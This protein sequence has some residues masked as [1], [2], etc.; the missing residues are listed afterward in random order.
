MERNE[1]GTIL[2]AADHWA[3][4]AGVRPAYTFLVSGDA[5]GELS[6]ITFAEL[7]RRARV[8]AAY[9]RSQCDLKDRIILLY[10]PGIEYIV[11][12]LGVMYAG[13][14]A[15]PAYPPHKH[16]SA[17]L[18]GIAEDA[19][20]VMALTTSAA[21]ERVKHAL[22]DTSVPVRCGATDTLEL[23]ETL[24]DKK[25]PRADDIAFLQYTSGSTGAPRGVCV[26]H[27]GL[28]HNQR[29][30]RH[31]FGTGP[32]SKVISWLPLYHDMGLVG[33]VFHTLYLGIESVL[34]SPTHFIQRPLRWLEAISTFKA[35][36][37]GGPNSAFALCAERMTP[38]KQAF[39]DLSS[40]SVAFNG[41]ER[42][43]PET[44]EHFA[45]VFAPCGFRLQA[46]YPC[47]GLAEATLVV[48]A[49]RPRRAAAT[50]ANSAEGAENTSASRDA[51]HPLVASCGGPVLDTEV[52]IVDPS[53]QC[54]L[55]ERRIGE[56][57][58]RNP[59]IGI[60][61]WSRRNGAN[62][63]FD[64]RL[65]AR[66]EYRYLRTGDLGFLYDG[67]LFPAGRLKDLIVIDGVNH[68]PEDLERTAAESHPNLV[69]NGAAAFAV[70]DGTRERVVIVAEVRHRAKDLDQ[71]IR[72]IQRAVSMEH[73]LS[74]DGIILIGAASLPRTSSG[75]VQRRETRR[76]FLSGQ[77]H[78]VGEWRASR[79]I[80]QN[81]GLARFQDAPPDHDDFALATWI[82]RQIGHRLGGAVVG[83]NEPLDGAGL[84][85]LAVA[86]IVHH[87]EMSL[88]RTVPMELFFGETTALQIAE[89]VLSQAPVR[90][91]VRHGSGSDHPLT[92]SQLSLW[93][94]HQMHPA[95]DPYH[96]ASTIRITGRL[97]RDTVRRAIESLVAR[98]AAL[99]TTVTDAPR[100]CVQ[101][102]VNSNLKIVDA[103]GWS[104]EH[105][106]T[107]MTYAIDEEI[108]LAQGP[109]AKFVLYVLAPEIHVL[110]MVVHHII[111]DGW[112]ME[113]LQRDFARL[114][115]AACEGRP[116]DSAATSFI[117]YQQWQQERLQM[118]DI[119]D[120]VRYWTQQLKSS[121][122]LYIPSGSGLR[123]SAHHPVELSSHC[124]AHL[125]KQ[126]GVS[127]FVILATGMQ[128]ALHH[129][130]SHTDISFGT[131][132]ANRPNA[133]MRGIV[134]MIANQLVLRRHVV[135]E[136]TFAELAREN[137][138]LVADALR[139][140][141]VPFSWVVSAAQPPRQFGQNP[142][143]R[144]MFTYRNRPL[145][146]QHVEGLLM[147]PGELA[148]RHPKFDVTLALTHDSNTFSGFWEFNS[149]TVETKWAERLTSSFKNALQCA[150][151]SPSCQIRELLHSTD[152][153][154]A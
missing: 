87:L 22:R 131:D 137:R 55:P 102:R 91:T 6:S 150:T 130:T 121:D 95:D 79:E 74:L 77:L 149:A 62:I 103:T 127:P 9:L 69:R 128:V 45:E 133:W 94:L 42:V 78:L 147:C 56:I 99:R 151:A 50:P 67:E 104:Q 41:S 107:E 59:A 40:W 72:G 19:R 12:L 145:P 43:R 15:V 13:A 108:N 90:W 76:R 136:K 73:R 98:H 71:V 39:L 3:D 80:S 105:L 61:Y 132:T 36:I 26:T 118:P 7:R 92:P 129:V 49:G 140:Q 144:L 153:A 89:A 5:K 148:G 25:F 101:V 66:P 120:H 81:A 96:I 60:G 17:R 154:L 106:T 27:S 124:A 100:L 70:E 146:V 46:F 54:V 11:G 57:W 88:G 86:A 114:Y 44:M 47:Y 48:T 64:G 37:S 125:S 84:D 8:L 4:Q 93:V 18:L 75:K 152:A 21:L 117:A 28:M 2:E 134:G 58:V 65:A 30:M 143:F 85:S 31:A 53:T 16:T 32:D 112:S 1:P 111:C 126:L 52:L 141:D 123:L 119:H 68:F 142:L 10:P 34:M 14:I 23:I 35:T 139:H 51:T 82:V 109:L 83:V 115:A 113:I 122:P 38:E 24:Q 29:M 138:I 135:P 63:T 97:D 20:P 33:T 116:P 110:L